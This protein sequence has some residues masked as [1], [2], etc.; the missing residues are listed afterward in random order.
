[1]RRGLGSVSV[2]LCLFFGG[3]PLA[4]AQSAP[5]ALPTQPPLIP[6]TLMGGR[7]GLL[8]KIWPDN[9]TRY[10][11]QCESWCNL[12]LVPG[13]YQVSVTEDGVSSSRRIRIREPEQLTLTPPSREARDVGS[14]LAIGGMVLGGLGSA[15]FLYGVARALPCAYADGATSNCPEH[16]GTLIFVGLAGMATGLAIGIPGIVLVFTNRGPRVDVERFAT[17]RSG[18][19]AL[20]FRLNGGGAPLGL[21]IGADF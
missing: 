20:Y 14:G 8:L 19:P 12:T 6:V 18:E 17:A 4:R 13:L 16:P 21:G 7:P 2:L 1:V 15:F 5:A 11:Q 3:L 10:T 9:D